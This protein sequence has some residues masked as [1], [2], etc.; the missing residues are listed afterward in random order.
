MY[1]RADVIRAFDVESRQKAAYI[2]EARKKVMSDLVKRM[3]GFD[4]QCPY[5]GR[6]SKTMTYKSKKCPYC[7]KSFTIF[8]ANK[9]SR[10]ADTEENR[11]KRY[12]IIQLSGLVLKGK[13]TVI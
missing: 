4:V 6:I 5:C 7:D 2:M 1:N 9:R 10:V 8:P 13:L 3:G 11:K 12:H